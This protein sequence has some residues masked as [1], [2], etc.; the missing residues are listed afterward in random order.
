MQESFGFMDHVKIGGI[1]YARFCDPQDGLII[2]WTR[3]ECL[4]RLSTLEISNLPNDQTKKAI[5]EW[6]TD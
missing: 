2:S 5:D 1:Y 3:T 4:D 6:P